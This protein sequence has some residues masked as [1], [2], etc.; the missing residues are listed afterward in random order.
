MG[1][2]TSVA[3]LGAGNGGCAAAADLTLRGFDVRL[4]TRSQSRIEPIIAAGGLTA[5]GAAGEGFARIA[6]VTDELP[7]AVVGADV[8]LLCVPASALEYFVPALVTMLRAD[9]MVVLNP[10]HLGTL[11]F[12]HAASRHRADELLLC[13]TATPTHVGR[14]QAPASVAI[15]HVSV[16]VA[17]AALPATRTDELQARISGLFP[18][19]VQASSI[20]ETGLRNLNAVEHPAQ[21]LL[22][23]GRLEHTRGDFLVYRDGTTPS[24]ARVIEKVDR[25]R[26][27]LAAALG[28]E[29]RS[30]VDYLESDGHTSAA[31]AATG[32]VFEAMGHRRANS[33]IKQPPSFDHPYLHEDVGWGIAPWIQL[34]R[35]FGV[36]V[37][38]MEALARTAGMVNGV[39]YIKDGLTLE[40]LGFEGLD[41]TEIK[42]LVMGESDG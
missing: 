16:D 39:D 22:N 24:V 36:P 25:E 20:L 40:R 13:E 26:M 37:P 15:S 5:T 42:Q 41:R 14:M 12:R 31:D 4:Y 32:R 8:V 28:V 6:T 10:G 19:I 33:Q 3:V 38:T 17:F 21:A 11:Y 18:S 1:D 35:E 30:F 34:A 27:E 7:R 9:Q 2:A 29:I 23:A